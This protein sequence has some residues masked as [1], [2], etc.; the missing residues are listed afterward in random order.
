[1]LALPNSQGITA[2]Y[3]VE[4]LDAFG[5]IR[6]ETGKIVESG[7]IE[8]NPYAMRG[9]FVCIYEENSSGERYFFSD[10]SRIWPVGREN[11]AVYLRRSPSRSHTGSGGET[12]SSIPSTATKIPNY[13]YFDKLWYWH[14]ENQNSI[15]AIIS[16][17]IMFGYY[18]AFH[19]D[20]FVPEIWD[21]VSSQATSSSNWVNW[22]Q[23]PGCGSMGLGTQYE[24]TERRDERFRDYLVGECE[25]HV[26]EFVQDTGLT[27][28]EQ[29]SLINQYL[30]E[31]DVSY[32]LDWSE[33]NLADS[34]SHR[35]TN[36][37][38]NTIDAG[39]PI[40]ANAD[41]HSYVAYGYDDNY[42]YAH[43]GD[44]Y[45]VRLIWSLFDDWDWN[46]RP[47]AIDI[48]PTSSHVHSNNYHSSITGTFYCTCGL[49]MKTLGT[50]AIPSISLP[51]SFGNGSASFS[52]NGHT[53]GV[54]YNRVKKDDMNY[55]VLDGTYD[56]STMEFSFDCDVWS[57]ELTGYTNY[58]GN[59]FEYYLVQTKTANG[60]WN[61]PYMIA[62]Y[63]NLFFEDESTRLTLNLDKNT[64]GIRIKV[65]RSATIHPKLTLKKLAFAIC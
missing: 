46:Y 64:R 17:Q 11:D 20:C 28:N 47:T 19:S 55:A 45:I 60:E 41:G 43:R 1:M 49:G 8:S 4:G 5:I 6:S 51:S 63:S 12:I 9:D 22:T 2:H 39:R 62:T 16:E 48:Q 52:Q 31:R 65:I 59:G 58:T 15:C 29:V 30:G 13:K 57:M 32:S 18:D 42:V 37:I 25:S 44:G 21:K 34:W 27:I 56:D 40:I 10:S 38:K 14:G 53:V 26:N 23:S 35:T 61:S 33:G 24:E 7:R 36:L 3:L 50:D 54:S